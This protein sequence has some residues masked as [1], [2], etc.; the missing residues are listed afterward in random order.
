MRCGSDR[1][2][3]ERHRRP[4]PRPSHPESYAGWV[5]W[6]G[7]R[8]GTDFPEGRLMRQ[9]REITRLPRAGNTA[10]SL[11]KDDA[12]RIYAFDVDEAGNFQGGE[13]WDVEHLERVVLYLITD[14]PTYKNVF[15]RDAQGL[16][17]LAAIHKAEAGEGGNRD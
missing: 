14:G 4:L 5:A 16:A 13:A 9:Y 10:V 2:F 11:G 17:V 12:G 15:L 7:E 3:K 8:D 1:L 6:A